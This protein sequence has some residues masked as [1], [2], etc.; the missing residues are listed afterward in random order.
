MRADIY[1]TGHAHK[2]WLSLD[3]LTQAKVLD[4]IRQLPR[5]NVAM[6]P[7]TLIWGEV[8]KHILKI[9]DKYC[10]V[11]RRSLPNPDVKALVI[12]LYI[13]LQDDTAVAEALNIYS[14]E[15]DQD[16]W[17]DLEDLDAELEQR[18]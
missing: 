16:K 4:A 11:F 7:Q 9:D 1:F 17:Y 12:V 10:A 14:E 15:C 6:L 3:L 2:N 8:I 5:G 18:I 13:G